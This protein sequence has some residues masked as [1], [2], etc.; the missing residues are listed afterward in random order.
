MRRDTSEPTRAVIRVLATTSADARPGRP[1]APA[2]DRPA[3]GSWWRGSW[4]RGSC[5]P[6]H[7]PAARRR[8]HGPGARNPTA[9]RHR[10]R[11]RPV[12]AHHEPPTT[13]P[14]YK[15][16]WR[17]EAPERSGPSRRTSKQPATRIRSPPGRFFSKL[18]EVSSK[19]SILSAGG[20][21]VV[22][23]LTDAGLDAVAAPIVVVAPGDRSTA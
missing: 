23:A 2:G 5:T 22:I 17:P 6:C 15:G 19:H 8:G 10:A 14:I 16:S 4:R 20:A 3:R 1:A 21:V 9:A 18:L 13:P 11:P 12:H 7:A